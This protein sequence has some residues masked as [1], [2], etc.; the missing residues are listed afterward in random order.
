MKEDSCRKLLL[1][2]AERMPELVFDI[3][4]ALK[5]DDK[6]EPEKPNTSIPGWCTCHNCQDMPSDAENLCCDTRPQ[7][8]ISQRPE[9][10]IYCFEPEVLDIANVMRNDVLVLAQDDDINRRRRH[11]AYRQFVL[12][13]CGH[14]GTGNSVVVRSCCV[15][16]IRRTFSDRNRQYRGFLPNR[17]V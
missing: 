15:L 10:D 11:A 3:S 12:W 13:R 1:N 7:N 9:F 17:L 4:S 2:V 8:C 6:V 16:R 14:L 5:V